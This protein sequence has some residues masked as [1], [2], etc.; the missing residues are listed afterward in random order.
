MRYFFLIISTI[1][2]I[3]LFSVQDTLTIYYT[4]VF[5]EM[6]ERI[7]SGF[8]DNNNCKIVSKKFITSDILLENREEIIEKKVD[9]LWGIDQ[10]NYY[11]IN[12]DTLFIEIDDHFFNRIYK[13]YLY[14]KQSKSLPVIADYF[15]FLFNSTMYSEV[16][17]YFGQFQD[18]KYQNQILMQNYDSSTCGKAAYFWSLAL[19]QSSGY[20]TFWKSI[21]KNIYSFEFDNDNA[22]KKFI[23][24][25]ASILF[26]S[27]SNMYVLKD[28]YEFLS[29]V[30]NEGC[31]GLIYQ[32]AQ[33]Q[34]SKE[35]ELA[36]KFFEYL[37]S[38]EIQLWMIDDLK[39]VS[40][41][42]SRHNLKKLIPENPKDTSLDFQNK[43]INNERK[44]WRN[45]WEKLFKKK[46]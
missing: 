39:L 3:N 36:D 21:N 8:E 37:L 11:Q 6:E 22:T 23:S 44:Y 17:K 34:F 5:P 13:D 26:T 19:F 9:I 25:E 42:D 16:P 31:F 28:K 40:A 24:G 18:V 41:L 30:P 33:T 35:N 43:V 46:K 12:K 10:T 20:R 1:I 15:V 14:K 4:S 45:H 38:R 32:L 27:I 29:I 7:F 2:A